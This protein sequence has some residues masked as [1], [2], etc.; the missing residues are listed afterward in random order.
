MT[1]AHAVGHL[2]AHVVRAFAVFWTATGPVIMLAVT[3]YMAS[4]ELAVTPELFLTVLGAVFAG[5]LA[6][7]VSVKNRNFGCASPKMS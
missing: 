6:M 2:I 7:F 3:P 4:G 5:G 1:G